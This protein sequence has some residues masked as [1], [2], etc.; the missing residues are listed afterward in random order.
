MIP[1]LPS[2]LTDLR[3]EPLQFDMLRHG[4]D[5]LALGLR[6]A[7]PRGQRPEAID[8]CFPIST[9]TGTS[10]KLGEQFCSAKLSEASATETAMELLASA[11]RSSRDA[12]P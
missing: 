4:V 7:E 11:G 1:S 6:F 8:A 12:T 5:L 2:S 3:L 9:T 10:G